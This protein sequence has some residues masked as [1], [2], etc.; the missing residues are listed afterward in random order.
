MWLLFALLSGALYT[1][2]SLLTRHVLR[3]QKDAWAFSFYFSLIGAVVSL[4]FML[5]EPTI[6]TDP[7]L[8]LLVLLVGL[9]ILGQN[10]LLFKSSNYIQASLSGAVTKFRLVWVFVF[11]VIV[12][13]AVFSW[14][15]LA[16]T[17]LTVCA[18]L[19][20]LRHFK[21][22]RSFKGVQLAFGATIFYAAVIILYKHLLTSFNAAS[23]TFFVTFMPV[24]VLNLIIMPNSIKRVR[25]L[26]M[27]S[28]RPVI[29]A[30]IL[31]AF[32][33]L[34]MNQALFLG[35]SSAVLITI[36]AFLILTLIGEHFILKEKDG[37]W[38]KIMAI[39]LAIS[40]AMIIRAY[41]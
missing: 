5:A 41:S 16:G 4:P 26:F 32:A 28:S 12:G 15:I 30:C 40:G 11:S 2:Q 21:Q 24:V 7:I 20:I 22:P 34:A 19:V 6:P 27:E 9:L 10:L 25:N 31:G 18:G 37:F 35:Q 38:L 13:Q 8:W 17:L 29:L 36:E 3:D 33:N 1:A 23:L 39:L 14:P